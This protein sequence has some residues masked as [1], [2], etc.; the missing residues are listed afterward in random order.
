[1]TVQYAPSSKKILQLLV[2][3]V[4]R[5]VLHQD[6][7]QAAALAFFTLFSLAPVLLVVV[8][9]AG[10]VFGQDAVRGQIV[11]KFQELMGSEA[12]RAIQAILKVAANPTS[13][14]D[15]AKIA[16]FVLL[17][18]GTTAVFVQLQEALNRVWDV[19]PRPGPIVRTLLKKRFVSFALVLAIGF[20]LL[21]S[22][23]VAA[24]MGAAE[25]WLQRRY[26][27]PLAT[28][29]AANEVLSFVV[30][31]ILI[32]LIYRILPDAE[33]SWREVGV[34]AVITATLFSIGKYLIG[35]YLGRTTVAS[36]YGAA[37]SVVV[38][39]L[40]VYYAALI[41]LLG[42][43]MTRAFTAVVEHKGVEPEPGA[44]KVETAMSTTPKTTAPAKTNAKAHEG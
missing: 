21:V 28:I 11:N 29:A 12:A 15:W 42:A 40:W 9:V 36:P 44:Q 3:T 2:N 19:E 39:L 20:L 27:L 7:T 25:G 8:A 26:S 35:L 33:I 17:A 41:L 22:L 14:R 1:M 31:V 13:D 16:G 23:A 18:I 5:F 37:G 6:A 4:D 34:G 10:S 43:E 38:I 32:A 30:L 24:M